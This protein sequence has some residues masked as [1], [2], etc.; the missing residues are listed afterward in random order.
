MPLE[1]DPD[2]NRIAGMMKRVIAGLDPAISITV[3]RL[4]QLNREDRDIGE[5]SD[6]VL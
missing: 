5:R 1:Q 3:A 2:A 6:A 4:Y